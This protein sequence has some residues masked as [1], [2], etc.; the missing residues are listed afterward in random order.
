[1]KLLKAVD[2]AILTGV[3]I[4]SRARRICEH[5]VGQPEILGTGAAEAA[6]ASGYLVLATGSCLGSMRGRAR[7]PL[8]ILGLWSIWDAA[9]A[10][11]GWPVMLPGY[12]RKVG[13]R[14]RT[15]SIAASRWFKLPVPI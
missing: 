9:T 8:H 4:S 13:W 10:P 7:G 1:M 11:R 2:L 15:P 5:G 12:P 6:Y 3:R 14:V